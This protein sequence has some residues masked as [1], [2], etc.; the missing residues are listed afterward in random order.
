[1]N[2]RNLSLCGLDEAGRGALAGPLVAAAVL[3]PNDYRRVLKKLDTPLR[4]GKTLTVNQR[5]KI[6]K[7]IIKK[8]I[9]YRTEIISAR[10]INNHGIGKSNR[11]IFRRL[12][13]KIEADKY[14]VDGNLKIGKIRG[15]MN[16]ESKP[17]A[18]A[19]I[20]AVIVAGIIAKF[21]RD[22]IMRKLH[23]KY[24]QYGWNSN[25]GYGTKKHIESIRYFGI[26]RY[27]R[28]IFVTT[29]EKNMIKQFK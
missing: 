14:I 25:A 12:I 8:C 3:L 22:K 15:R 13:R 24:P 6:I 17:H 7:Y 16:I 10:I 11:E 29:A 9:R 19:E 2:S 27:H 1:M 5:R 4:D 23:N 18:D 26:C 28:N 20:P 21:T